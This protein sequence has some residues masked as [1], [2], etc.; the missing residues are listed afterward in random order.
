VGDEVRLVGLVEPDAIGLLGFGTVS[1]RG[2]D[3]ELASRDTWSSHWAF[4]IAPAF[5]VVAV[6]RVDAQ[7][8]PL[9]G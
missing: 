9:G 3:E 6:D 2:I 4:V 7:R 8:L 5:G 1:A